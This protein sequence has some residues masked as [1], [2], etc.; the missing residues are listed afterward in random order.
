MMEI[1]EKFITKHFTKTKTKKTGFVLH[2][3]VTKDLQGI[4]NT[5]MS[6]PPRERLASAHYGISEDGEIWQ[7]VPDEYIAW[8]AGNVNRFT[9]GIE[10]CGGY[11]L[12]DGSRAKPTEACMR[13]SAQLIKFLSDKY[14][15]V[16][17]REN[18]KGHKEHMAT[19]CPGSLDIEFIVSCIN[20]V[21]KPVK[22]A[23]D[24]AVEKKD[25]IKEKYGIDIMRV[26]DDS[27]MTR[28]EV[29][30]SLTKMWDAIDIKLKQNNLIK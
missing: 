13:A 3:S 6:S 16:P 15:I 2:W 14:G 12:P 21:G 5:F 23:L 27:T 26:I 19:A 11:L 28:K 10:H 29:L 4:Y 8:H 9:I 24:L 7:F 20:E 30:M 1:K 18:I 25:L 22:S 17:N